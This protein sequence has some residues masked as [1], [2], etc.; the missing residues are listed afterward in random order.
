MAQKT[1]SLKE[2]QKIAEKL[3]R[4]ARLLEEIWDLERDVER[5]VGHDLDYMF[6][7]YITPAA[8]IGKDISVS[9]VEEMLDD[10]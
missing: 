4:A 9:D 3:T 10:D 1:L 8:V 5:I 2:N 6:D 7:L